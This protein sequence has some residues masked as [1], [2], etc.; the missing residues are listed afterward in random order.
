MNDEKNG[1]KVEHSLD[2]S[3][4]SQIWLKNMHFNLVFKFYHNTFII[5]K[6]Y[7]DFM[8]NIFVKVWD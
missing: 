5:V 4:I 1:K 7:D 3:K 8:I 6:Y 2:T